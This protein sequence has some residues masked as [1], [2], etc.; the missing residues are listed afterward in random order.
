M[1]NGKTD[2]VLN[3]F[4]W[5]YQNGVGPTAGGPGPSCAVGL[6]ITPALFSLL[7][8]RLGSAFIRF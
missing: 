7:L 8:D 2:G 1:Q 3:L 4:G 6:T 5:V